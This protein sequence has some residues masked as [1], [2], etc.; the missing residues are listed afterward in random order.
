MQAGRDFPTAAPEPEVSIRAALMERPARA[1]VARQERLSDALMHPKK[2]FDQR[3][4]ADI[5]PEPPVHPPTG[6]CHE[7][8]CLKCGELGSIF[9]G[10]Y[11]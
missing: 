5:V 9:S 3:H 1:G 10:G 8:E 7:R 4:V 11:Q 6:P 2:E